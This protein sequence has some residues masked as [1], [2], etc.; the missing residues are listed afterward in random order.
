MNDINAAI[1]E[2]IFGWTVDKERGIYTDP[3]VES[4]HGKACPDFLV[5]KEA[6]D[7]LRDKM[8][9]RQFEL[10]VIQNPINEGENIG[11]TFTAIFTKANADFE[12]TEA[13]E[14]LAVCRAALKAVRGTK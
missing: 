1:C 7:M 10:R 12:Q 13:H 4:G 9:E 8:S 5:L 6:Q 11:K 2:L 14:Y 3:G